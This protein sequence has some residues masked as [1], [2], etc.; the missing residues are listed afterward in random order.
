MIHDA[1]MI[2]ASCEVC[3]AAML[4]EQTRGRP[5]RYCKSPECQHV[6]KLAR[7]RE[8]RNRVTVPVTTVTFGTNA[9][10]IATVAELYLAAG[11]VVADVTYSS[12][13]FWKKV[14]LSRYTML[15]SDL[16]P[17]SPGVLA[18]DFRALPY[19]DGSVDTVVFDPPY[20][21]SPG[22]GMLKD[23]YNGRATTDMI[24]YADIMALYED[25][26]TEAVRVLHDGGQLWVKCKDT[27]ASERQR[28]SHITVFELADKLGLYARDLFLLV[29][30]AP[31]S[32]TTGRWARQ[33][34]ARKVHSYLWIFETGGYRRRA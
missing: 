10:L 2:F 25:G 22:K 31:S 6:G 3:G 20:I 29:P 5:R 8:R 24:T 15:A 16:M 11:A 21:H 26:M 17:H 19:R 9:E 1:K 12:G 28:W 27:L 13:R 23:R 33:I 32:V 34:H 4:G 30:P 14:N 7:Q 18:A